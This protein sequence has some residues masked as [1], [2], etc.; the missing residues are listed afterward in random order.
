MNIG[1]EAKRIFENRSGLGN[2]GRNMINL[3]DRFYP[4]N[5]YKLFAPKLTKLYSTPCSSEVIT[6]RT[7]LF[8]FFKSFWR[9]YKVAK[10][11]NINKIDVFHGLSHVL[12]YGI[13]KT[14]VP[15]VVTIH[16]LIFIRY[17][18]YYKKF[19]RYIYRHI[20]LSSCQRATKIIA[21]SNQTKSDLINYFKIIPEKIEVIYQS[22][23]SCFYNRLSEKRKTSIRLK[24]KL[25]QKYILCVGTIEQRKNQLALL[26]AVVAEKVDTTVVILGRPTEYINIL[27]QFISESGIR[28]QVIFLHH[29]TTD[30]LQ[31]IY[32][33]AE[34]MVYP[35]FFE[36]F[37][38]PVLEAQASGCAVI[39]SNM[40][41]L[42]EA[43]GEGALYINPADISEI[44]QAIRNVLLN[45]KLKEDLIEKGI[46]NAQLF[47]EKLAAERLMK[48]YNDLK[49][50]NR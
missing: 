22:C 4:E 47:S 49:G 5:R 3:L 24:Y 26:E 36:G 15:S 48:L 43:G 41:S 28:E 39:T 25:P 30:E 31:G 17:P 9:L 50:C 16:D 40:S 32:Q 2:Y 23:D 18:E 33:M 7:F 35:S 10:L 38:L 27:N 34:V 8:V 29:T 12:P 13:E 21:I 37:G 6:P 45:P 20:Y 46:A 14:G 44:G 42:P 11:L 1:F 19:D